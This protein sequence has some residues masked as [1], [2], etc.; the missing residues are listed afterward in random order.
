M[1]RVYSQATGNLALEGNLIGTGYS[2]NG[3]GLN[4][5]AM[6]DDPD[7]GPIPQG[8]YTIGPACHDPEKGP[9]VMELQPDPANQMFGR[10]GFLIHGDNFA[11]NHSASHGC[12]ILGPDI[13]KQISAS[14]D[15]ALT[16][17]G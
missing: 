1:P 12:I 15:R 11:M 2:G 4:N 6:Q 13:R 16:V 9:V 7:I 17:T 8:A 5:P 10:S 14:A 3:T